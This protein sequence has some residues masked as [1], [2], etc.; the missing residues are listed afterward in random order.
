MDGSVLREDKG[1]EVKDKGAVIEPNVAANGS[2]EAIFD[3]F[4]RWGYLEA[5]L[6]PLGD[7]KPE[8]VP[9][10]QM[11]G[12]TADEARRIYCGSVGAEFMHIADGE[13]RRWVAE[14][15]EAPAME[16]D[17]AWI[18][19]RLVRSEVFEQVVQSRYLGTKRFSLEGL[20]S[21][22]PLLDEAL[23]TAAERGA[24]EVLLGMSHRG[25]LSVMIHIV[26]RSAADI[27]ARFEDVDARSVMGGGDVKYH[28]GATGQYQLR[29][30]AQRTGRKT[31]W[32]NGRSAA[33]HRRP[34]RTTAAYAVMVWHDRRARSGRRSH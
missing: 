11:G 6:D 8:A 16:P 17:R 26:G 25:R 10:L 13:K 23:D 15:M 32:A 22:I 19:D 33:A 34:C 9:E 20:T 3:E 12:E 21:L 7:F 31:I 1:N 14:R 18:L 4:R 24:E 5:E 30:A 29:A 28:I 2:R 27:F